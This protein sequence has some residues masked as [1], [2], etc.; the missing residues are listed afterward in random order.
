MLHTWACKLFSIT[1]ELVIHPELA[2]IGEYC[3]E[4]SNETCETDLD[5]QGYKC[6]RCEFFVMYSSFLL[7]RLHVW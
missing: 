6:G 1:V 5:C 3:D 2:Q 7:S 4:A